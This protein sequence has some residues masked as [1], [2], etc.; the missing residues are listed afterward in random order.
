MKLLPFIAFLILLCS[1]SKNYSLRTFENNFHPKGKTYFLKNQANS[2]EEKGYQAL[3][4]TV[5]REAG[6]KK[7]DLKEKADYTII[8]QYGVSKNGSQTQSYCSQYGCS[9]TSNSLYQIDLSLKVF[10]KD[11][12]EIYST[13]VATIRENGIFYDSSQC[14]FEALRR[15]IPSKTGVKHLRILTP[16]D[17][18]KDYHIKDLTEEIMKS[19]NHEYW[20][21]KAQIRKERKMRKEL[22][23]EFYQNSNIEFEEKKQ[24]SSQ[25]KSRFYSN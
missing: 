3:A 1:C 6:M 15:T 7:A 4:E 21:E 22:E 9:A 20:V 16:C 13:W 8:Y 25:R 12:E 18:F 10:D 5:F 24:S 23:K 14:I 11:S 19:D 17:Y 2:L